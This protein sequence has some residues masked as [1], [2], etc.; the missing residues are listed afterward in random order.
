MR[1]QFKHSGWGLLF[2]LWLAA[3]CGGITRS[4]V[5]NTAGARAYRMR[6]DRP[7]RVT[8]GDI[9]ADRDLDADLQQAVA[10]YLQHQTLATLGRHAIF[11]LVDTSD[12]SGDLLKQFMQTPAPPAA[13]ADVDGRMNM[14]LIKMKE[15]KGATVRVGLISQQSKFA[16]ATIRARLVL[17]NGRTY[18]ATGTGK[19]SKGAWGVVA[20]T[21]R[22]AMDRKDGVWELDGSMAGSACAEALQAAV[23]DVARQLHGDVKRFKDSELEDWLQAASPRTGRGTR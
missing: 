2:I 15:Q 8:T 16:T 11:E 3:G 1:I 5:D 23:A 21:D 7:V 6:A 14:E 10:R 4:A 12:R 18:E 13:Q 20:M 19:A 17:A 22:K 9:T